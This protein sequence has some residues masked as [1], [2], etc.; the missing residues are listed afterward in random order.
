MTEI[1]IIVA[2]WDK[3]IDK[4]HE[5]ALWGKENK[6]FDQGDS[7]TWVYMCHTTHETNEN[8]CILLYVNCVC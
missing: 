5:G 1:K 2:S 6:S 8:L 4:E 3:E 7:L